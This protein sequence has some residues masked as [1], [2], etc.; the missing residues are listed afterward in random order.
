MDKRIDGCFERLEK[1]LANL[2]DSVS[3]Y[4]PS[5][6]QARE[7]ELADTELSKGLEEGEE[8]HFPPF[9]LFLLQAQLRTNFRQFKLT[10]ITICGSNN[11]AS[12][13]PRLIRKSARRCRVWRQLAKTLLLPRLRFSH[14]DPAF[15][16]VMRNCFDMPAESARRLCLLRV[17][18]TPSLPPQAPKRL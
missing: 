16:S 3:K 4:H 10:K 2:I 17:P 11:C 7:L 15:P 18:S 8:Y 13:Q 12:P 1:A 14:Q 9:L 5:T 6:T